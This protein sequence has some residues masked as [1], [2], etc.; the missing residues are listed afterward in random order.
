MEDTGKPFK[1]SLVDVRTSLTA[2][3]GFAQLYVEANPQHS[4]AITEF[5]G[6]ITT[7]EHELADAVYG[8]RA[9]D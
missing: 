3:I 5:V 6:A 4:A 7:L 9:P 2:A 1:A 8:P